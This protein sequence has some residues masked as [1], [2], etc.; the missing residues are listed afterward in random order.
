MN[1]RYKHIIM[2]WRALRYGIGLRSAV[3]PNACFHLDTNNNIKCDNASGIDII[4]QA[5]PEG[6]LEIYHNVLITGHHPIAQSLSG[7]PINSSSDEALRNYRANRNFLYN[8]QRFQKPLQIE[9][10]ILL[11]NWFGHFGHWVFEQ[12]PRIIRAQHLTDFTII[13]NRGEPVKFKSELLATIGRNNIHIYDGQPLHVATFAQIASPLISPQNVQSLRE[14]ASKLPITKGP[15]RLFLSR[16]NNPRKV[17]NFTQIL[18]ILRKHGIHTWSPESDSILDQIAKFRQAQF[19][20]GLHG[21][22]LRNAIFMQGGHAVEIN[23]NFRE[24]GQ[25]A[26]LQYAPVQYHSLNSETQSSKSSG[27]EV[28]PI[29]L[30]DFLTELLK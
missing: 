16:Q 7:K 10:A 8:K 1:Q 25:Q 19:V 20:I 29:Q 24:Y 11:D 30:D 12:F 23:G 9:K 28:D 3:T 5:H 22:A 26:I 15:E 13:L 17:K 18:P 14:F 27:V 21:S 4:R 6:L 2:Q